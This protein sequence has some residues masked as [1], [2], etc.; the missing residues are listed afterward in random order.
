MGEGVPAGLMW[1]TMDGSFIE[2]TPVLAQKIFF[3]AA[4]QDSALFQYAESLRQQV[5][6]SN[7]PEQVDIVNNWPTTFQTSTEVVG[8]E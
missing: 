2:M 8:A 7:D 1:K 4:G 5:K 6:E 3:A